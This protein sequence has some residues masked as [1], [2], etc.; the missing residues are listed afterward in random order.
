MSEYRRISLRKSD[1]A[2]I[3]LIVCYLDLAAKE[4]QGPTNIPWRCA[5]KC[6]SLFLITIMG[7]CITTN[8]PGGKRLD[9]NR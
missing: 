8:R 2:Y 6:S 4:R 5:G 3:S 1:V 7:S 9:S